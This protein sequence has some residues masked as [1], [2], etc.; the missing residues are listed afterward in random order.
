MSLENLSMTSDYPMDKIVFFWEGEVTFTS[1]ITTPAAFI[2]HNLPFAPLVFG[3]F[4]EDNWATTYTEPCYEPWVVLLSHNNNIEV[5]AYKAGGGGKV[6]IR[7]FGFEPSGD[8][9]L[10]PTSTQASAFVLNSD[11]G[12]LKLYAAGSVIT[13]DG[14]NASISH[15]LGFVPIVMGWISYPDGIQRWEQS[16]GIAG[17]SKQGIEISDTKMMF[18]NDGTVDPGSVFY[19]RIYANEA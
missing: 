7:M 17:G 18:H 16:R 10:P 8:S 11:Y 14:G 1:S 15:N 5:R 9:I 13:D 4:T 2:P 6:K 3:V 19:Y 12:Y